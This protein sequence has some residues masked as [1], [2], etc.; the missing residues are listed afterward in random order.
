MENASLV[1]SGTTLLKRSNCLVFFFQ[2]SKLHCKNYLSGKEFEASPLLVPIL[3]KLDRWRPLRSLEELFREY[4]PASIRKSVEQLIASTAVLVRGGLQSKRES[5]LSDWETWGV[6]ARFFHLATKRTHTQEITIDEARFNRALKRHDPPPPPIK[7]YRA[8]ARVKLPDPSK[9]LH[10][11]LPEVLLRRRTHRQFGPDG[12]SLEQLSTL[13]R[14]TWGFTS[15]IRWPG[16]GRLP[17]KTSPSG[18]A[19]HSLEVYLW[20]SRV[21]GLSTGVYHYRPDRHELELLNR[22]SVADQMAK[23]CGHQE[24]VQHCSVLFVMTSV[25]ARVTWRYR[26]SRAYRVILLEAG[27]FGQTFC[28]VATW[29]GLAPFCTAALDDEKIEHDLDL[30][31]GEAVLYAVGVGTCATCT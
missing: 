18:G 23:V 25:L 29:L 28:L 1:K 27:H 5:A 6:E 7:Q 21:R 30:N 10:G 14:L 20:C 9:Q 11:Q 15:H 4:S 26:F 13:L 24:W 19:R 22:G 17:V 16:L 2:G 3:D 31:A 12:V 8:R